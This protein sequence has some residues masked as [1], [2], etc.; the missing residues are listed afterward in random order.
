MV[1]VV[2]V[3]VEVDDGSGGIEE[4]VEMVVKVLPKVLT[5]LYWLYCVVDDVMIEVKVALVA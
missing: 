1:V 4:M 3:A 5:R 2:V